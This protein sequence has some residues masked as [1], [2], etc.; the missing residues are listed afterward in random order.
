[1]PARQQMEGFSPG[2]DWARMQVRA[3]PPRINRLHHSPQQQ[4]QKPSCQTDS[5]LE[6]A[7]FLGLRVIPHASAMPSPHPP[8]NTTSGPWLLRP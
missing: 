8:P 1:M 4:S 3:P 5:Q 2:D 7:P 6:D